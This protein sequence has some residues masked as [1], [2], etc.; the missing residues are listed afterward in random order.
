MSTVMAAHIYNFTRL[1]HRIESSLY[2]IL[3]TAYKSNNRAIGG[4]TRVNVK[5]TYTIT[6]LYNIGYLFDYTLVTPFT[7]IRHALYYLPCLCHSI[8][9]NIKL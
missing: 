4:L 8:K 1:L 2:H 7:K 6:S 9:S 5:Q 3:R